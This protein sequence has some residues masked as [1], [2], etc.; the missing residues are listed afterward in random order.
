MAYTDDLPAVVEQHHVDHNLYADNTQLSDYPSIACISDAVANIENCITSI[1]NK[2][3]ASKRLQLNPT[4]SEIIWFGTT[5]SL[6]RL[7]GLN[8]GQHVG[9]DII[10]PVDIVGDLGVLPDT[11]LTTKSTSARSR[12]FASTPCSI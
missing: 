4:K 6:H 12:A 7:Q 5:T 9:A 10:T 11:K 2:W 3:C 8:L 1:I